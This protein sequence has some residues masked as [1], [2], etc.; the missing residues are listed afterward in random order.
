MQLVCGIKLPSFSI[1]AFKLS[2]KRGESNNNLYQE[3]FL[4]A[5]L[6]QEFN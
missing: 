6:N 4:S 2:L 1:T 5:Q 3:Y